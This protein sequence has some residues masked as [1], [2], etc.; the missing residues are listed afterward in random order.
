MMY[1]ALKRVAAET[2]TTATVPTPLYPGSYRR[3]CVSSSWKTLV[4]VYNWITSDEC[5]EFQ[6]VS[7]KNVASAK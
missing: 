7:P 4:F 6:K 1:A 3:L 2:A 5:F